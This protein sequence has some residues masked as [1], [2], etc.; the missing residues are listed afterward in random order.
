MSVFQKIK[1]LAM[2][3]AVSFNL[4]LLVLLLLNVAAQETVI[5]PENRDV[6]HLAS[7][8]II[9]AVVPEPIV[10]AAVVEAVVLPEVIEPVVVEEIIPP[11]VVKEVEIK[12]RKVVKKVLRSEKIEPPVVEPEPPP[13]PVVEPIVEEIVE[14]QPEVVPIPPPAVQQTAE[15]AE[16][17]V[18]PPVVAALVVPDL[19]MQKR[20]QAAMAAQTKA[21]QEASLAELVARLER[22]K[23][24]PKMARRLNLS[25]TVKLRI[26]LE[27]DG[28]I[29]HYELVEYGNTPKVLRRAALATVRRAAKTPL[30]KIELTKPLSVVIPI[31]YELL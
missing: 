16:T 26:I 18:T 1:S 6:L 13:E 4:L 9:K 24:F 29:S 21:R 19:D 3:T 27:P 25:G 12:P 7:L 23:R 10:P 28:V 2:L 8:N 14:P 20:Q 31:V 17:I 30:A 22:E 5:E 15:V 11:K